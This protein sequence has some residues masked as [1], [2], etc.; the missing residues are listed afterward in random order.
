MLGSKSSPLPL[1]NF[2]A[3]EPM[4]AS[5]RGWKIQFT[6][7]SEQ[8]GQWPPERERGGAGRDVRQMKA[9]VLKRKSE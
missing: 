3:A 8:L 2:M 7:K 9:G 6:G 4:V 5:Q 1:C